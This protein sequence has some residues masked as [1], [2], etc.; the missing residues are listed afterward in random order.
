M[1]AQNNTEFFDVRGLL[2]YDPVLSDDSVQGSAVAFPFVQNHTDLFSL[3]SSTME[4]LAGLDVSCGFTTFR[5]NSLVFP[6]TG[7]LPPSPSE[8]R[9]CDLWDTIFECVPIFSS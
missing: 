9:Q 2:I 7:P 6:P 1:Q 8:S 3:S 4:T 5:E